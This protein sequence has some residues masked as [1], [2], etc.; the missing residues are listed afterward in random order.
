VLETDS[1]YLAPVPYRGKRNEPAYLANVLEKLADIYGISSNDIA[2]QTTKNAKQ[3][4]KL[5]L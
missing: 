5:D 3:L 1:P 2:S 4:F